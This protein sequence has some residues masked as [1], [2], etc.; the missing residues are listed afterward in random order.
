[1]RSR[2][3]VHSNIIDMIENDDFLVRPSVADAIELAIILVAGL[4]LISFVPSLSAITTII[5]FVPMAGVLLGVAGICT[6]KSPC[7]LTG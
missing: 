1:M 2:V 4:I 3:E 7:W 6:R 5:F